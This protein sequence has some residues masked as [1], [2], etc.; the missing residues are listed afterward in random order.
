VRPLSDAFR[1]GRPSVPELAA[2]AIIILGDPHR[3]LLLHHRGE[4]RWCFPKG[5][6][7]P[8][9]TLQMAAARE[10]E[11]EAGLTD[12]QIE[13]ELGEVSYRFYDPARDVNV[14]KTAVYFLASSRTERVRLEATFDAHR[15]AP[16][17]EATRLVPFETDRSL[18]RKAAERLG[19]E[20]QRRKVR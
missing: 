9:E 2:G 6:V 15:W 14:F 7:D 17:D 5:H 3:I 20:S 11:E 16:L 12:L 4:D 10:I 13:D 19:A 18:L 1:P 8:G